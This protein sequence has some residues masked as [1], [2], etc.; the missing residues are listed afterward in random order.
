MAFGIPCPVWIQ[1]ELAGRSDTSRLQAIQPPLR[2]QPVAIASLKC[3]M[4]RDGDDES[5]GLWLVEADVGD[6]VKRHSNGN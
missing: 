1:K 5:G 2:W 3:S 4:R 6:S